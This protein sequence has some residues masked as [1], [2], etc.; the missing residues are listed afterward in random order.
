MLR[1]PWSGINY[2]FAGG[3]TFIASPRAKRLATGLAQTMRRLDGRRMACF[4]EW[5]PPAIAAARRGQTAAETSLPL[6]PQ[7]TMLCSAIDSPVAGGATQ[8]PFKM[9]DFQP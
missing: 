8:S 6:R 3:K 9:S 2:S 5:R 4:R 7:P 1:P